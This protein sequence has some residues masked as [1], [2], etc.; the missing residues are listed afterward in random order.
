MS[1]AQRVK[2]FLT[3]LLMIFFAL[4]LIYKPEEGYPLVIVVLS[5]S[6][7]LYGVRS[8]IYFFTMARF[9][10]GGKTSLYKG[11]ILFDLGMF[12]MT[13]AKIPDTYIMLYLV[14]VNLFT[15]G[16]DILSAVDSKRSGSPSWKLKLAGGAVS[17]L[18]AIACVV[19]GRD[20]AVM[21]Y[22]YCS[23][24]I[25]SAIFRIISAFRKT[26]VVYIQ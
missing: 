21:V 8:L 17:V 19:F 4:I 23:G 18:A 6:L 22:I 26:A 16:V 1:K 14:A 13:L 12:T 10:V 11:I 25:Y 24:L 7:L 9:M 5:I 15:G 2:D 20:H 3:G